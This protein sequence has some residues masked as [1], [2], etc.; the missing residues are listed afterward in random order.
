MSQQASAMAVGS[1]DMI[2]T[3]H[4]V[5]QAL[6][7]DRLSS[8]DVTSEVRGKSVENDW[9]GVRREQRARAGC[10]VKVEEALPNFDGLAHWQGRNTDLNRKGP[11]TAET[12]ALRLMGEI[13]VG[14]SFAKSEKHTTHTQH[15]HNTHNVRRCVR[16]RNKEK[17]FCYSVQKRLSSLS[18]ISQYPLA[19]RSKDF[20]FRK[21]KLLGVSPECRTRSGY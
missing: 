21:V 17:L 6:H 8:A 1:R 3:C 20:N 2:D 10:T 7:K 9:F 11:I 13:R 16:S 15:T 4:G 14:W 12:L 5:A 18:P 19:K